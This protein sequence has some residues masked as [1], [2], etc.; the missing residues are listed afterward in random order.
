MV[1]GGNTKPHI[2]LRNV[3]LSFCYSLS[4]TIT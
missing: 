1:S 4:K 3:G 2:A